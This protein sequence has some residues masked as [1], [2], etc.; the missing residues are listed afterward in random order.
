MHCDLSPVSH[1]GIVIGG[2]NTTGAPLT[3][4]QEGGVGLQESKGTTPRNGKIG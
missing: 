2:N 4:R 3:F 1:P